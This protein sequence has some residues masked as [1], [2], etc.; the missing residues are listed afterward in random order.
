AFW[1]CDFGARGWAAGAAALDA[2]GDRV[3]AL[4]AAAS[5]RFIS[6]SDLDLALELALARL[7]IENTFDPPASAPLARAAAAAPSP[8]PDWPP[9][10]LRAAIH[11]RILALLLIR[12]L[13]H[14]GITV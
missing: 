11:P 6:G 12:A 13:A 9:H 5:D 14:R 2:S 7:L 4:I 1:L 3:R 10:P 8:P